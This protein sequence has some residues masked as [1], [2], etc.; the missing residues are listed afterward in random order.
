MKLEWL[1]SH[2]HGK[3][4]I[5]CVEIWTHRNRPAVAWSAGQSWANKLTTIAPVN[6]RQ[7]RSLKTLYNLCLTSKLFYCEF[8]IHLYR[9]LD[10]CIDMIDESNPH[11]V[12]TRTLLV[13]GTWSLGD[14]EFDEVVQRLVTKMPR[15]ESF[16]YAP[17]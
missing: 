4:N 9:E 2:N 15:L 7:V 13:R 6:L 10:T 17:I 12:H 3:R 14:D 5:G 8:S 16:E 1:S 11:L